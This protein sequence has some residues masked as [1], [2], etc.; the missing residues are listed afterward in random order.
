MESENADEK[1][2][3]NIEDYFLS[4]LLEFCCFKPK[5]LTSNVICIIFQKSLQRFDKFISSSI[6]SD[7]VNKGKVGQI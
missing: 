1:Y 7:I 2:E 3:L 4:K 5:Y 6:I